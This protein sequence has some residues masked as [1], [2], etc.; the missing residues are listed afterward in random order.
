MQA[1]DISRQV[2]TALSIPLG[3]ALNF[4]PIRGETVSSAVDNDGEIALNAAG[5]AF[6]IWGLIFAWQLVYTV[7]QA[8]PVQRENPVLRRVGWWTALNGIATGLWAVAITQGR[9]G[10]GWG[11]I[12]VM[13]AALIA[14]EVQIG[15]AGALGRLDRWLVR[16]PYRVNLGWIC[17]ATILAT[18]SFLRNVVGWDGGAIS[19]A[20]WGVAGVA[21][22]ALLGILMLVLRGNVAF[23]GVIVWALLGVASGSAGVPAIAQAALVF[24]VV[25]GVSLLVFVSYRGSP[26]LRRRRSASAV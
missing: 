16:A 17:V 21:A 24:A 8:A 18:G 12:L 3:I 23:A 22:A 10:L 15:R 26:A 5:Y 2:V 11:L 19:E 25:L 13:L 1:K 20:G 6:S 7:Y 9:F 14:I 4:I